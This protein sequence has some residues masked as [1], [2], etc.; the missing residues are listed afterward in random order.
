MI[1]RVYQI[2]VLYCLGK[3]ALIKKKPHAVTFVT[4]QGFQVLLCCF[5]CQALHDF[6]IFRLIVSVTE[7]QLYHS[8]SIVSLGLGVKS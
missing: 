6:V 8:H 5:S 7:Q 1:R 3:N 2:G 4:A